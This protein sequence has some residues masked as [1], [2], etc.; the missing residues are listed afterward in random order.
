MTANLFPTHFSSLR[1]EANPKEHIVWLLD[2][3][4]WQSEAGKN[5]ATSV[6]RERPAKPWQAEYTAC[7]F[8]KGEE[9]T[10]RFVAWIADKIGLDGKLGENKDAMERIAKRVQ[11][12]I[13]PTV[14]ARKLSIQFPSSKGV[15]Q[16]QELR[17]SARTGTSVQTL[18]TGG[19]LESDGDII[20]V[21]T[22]RAFDPPAICHTRFA[23]PDGWAVISDIDDTIKYTQTPDAIG[24]LRTTFADVPS[25]IKD[26]PE[27]YSH[28]YDQLQSPAWFYLSASP[29]QLYPF[30]R[31]FLHEYYPA[32]QLILRNPD[33]SQG[34]MSSLLPSFLIDRNKYAGLRA[35]FTSLTAGVAVYKKGQMMKV[36]E[37]FGYRKFICIGD[38]TQSDPE[39]YADM[40]A[41]RP[42]WIQAIFIRK[43]TD[44]PHMEEKNKDE[45][46][47]KAFEKVPERV[48]KV[49]T[50]PEEVK[51]HLRHLAGQ[52]DL[53]G[54]NEGLERGNSPGNGEEAEHDEARSQQGEIQTRNPTELH[55]DP[56]RSAGSISR[57][58]QP[59]SETDRVNDAAFPDPKSA[60]FR[61]TEGP[62][63]HSEGPI[64]NLKRS[65]AKSTEVEK[66]VEE[67][68]D[69]VENDI[70]PT[71]AVEPVS[72]DSRLRVSEVVRDTIESGVSKDTSISS[73]I[74]NLQT[75]E[76][77]SA[78]AIPPPKVSA[79]GQVLPDSKPAMPVPEQI[80]ANSATPTSVKSHATS[81]NTLTPHAL[82][83]ETTEAD[84]E[85]SKP[86]T[87][88]A[89]TSDKAADPQPDSSAEPTED[90]TAATV[91]D[92][93]PAI[94]SSSLPSAATTVRNSQTI[95][96]LPAQIFSKPPESAPTPPTSP[97]DLNNEDKIGPAFAAAVPFSPQEAIGA[98]EAT[99]KS[100][101]KLDRK[102]S[103][104][105]SRPSSGLLQ[106]GVSWLTRTNSNK[107]R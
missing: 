75:P 60:Q 70:L 58:E 68:Q 100:E 1:R 27:L 93:K 17:P 29:Y 57:S 32:G 107:A 56:N 18:Q 83:E 43:V 71:T 90:K 54:V 47:A 61:G 31:D 22:L 19:D 99:Q 14:P 3:T 63:D 4:A 33:E 88:T 103:R 95:P 87:H 84:R 77:T 62:S 12:F 73:E 5:I 6:Q 42:G 76:S 74:T 38:S 67:S 46:F 26:M 8:A 30:L 80:S 40:Y 2:N 96:S 106:K 65:Q 16:T 24:I 7:F 50:R 91:E 48:W 23:G 86:P 44:V 51:E 101:A 34:R 98:I 41:K 78:E 35:L 105:L 36:N 13:N 49:F 15:L 28:I 69:D 102:G 66:K 53:G 82:D 11:P 81:L 20:K 97:A 64:T 10:G 94:A 72:A 85:V 52:D 45:R 21:S 37:K 92:S 39:A 59:R 9:D 104:A 25:P 79:T 55:S 89:S